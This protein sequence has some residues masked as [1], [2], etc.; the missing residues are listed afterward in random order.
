MSVDEVTILR[1]L[2]QS[3]ELLELIAEI[4]PAERLNQRRLRDRFPDELVRAGLVLFEARL[5]AAGKLPAAERLWLTRTGLEQSTA[6]E[7]AQHKAHRFR[8]YGEIFD[9]CSGIGV[10]AHALADVSET[11]AV[12]AIDSDAAMS[13]RCEWNQQVW[14][15]KGRVT[16][17]T[18]DVLEES[19]KHSIVHVDPDRRAGT[20]RPVKRLEQYVPNLDWMQKLTSDA[21]G[22]A[23]KVGPASNFLQKFPGC[24]IELISLHGECR[25]A[26]VWFG[27]LAGPCSFRA[28]VLPS[29]QTISVEPLSVWAEQASECEAWI[30]DPDPA[31]VRS[32]MLDAVAEQCGLK[33]LDPE[34]EYLTGQNCCSSPFVSAF[35]IEAVL[36]NQVSD[37]KKYLRA[38]PSAWYEIKCRR[39]PVKADVI[40]KQLPRGDGA[41]RVIFFARAGGRARIV[42]AVRELVSPVLPAVL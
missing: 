7:V 31:V 2:Q 36:P 17:R 24:E 20:D 16:C 19:W 3:P 34:E 35:R 23:I 26:T 15:P 1:T 12:T 42:V 37:L 25:E 30:F 28:T 41:P 5:A 11:A 22:G 40:Q 38:A 8:S 4:T 21:A 6:W 18:A 39:I 27:E 13:L 33:R 29:G 32:G 14:S 9:L 10:D